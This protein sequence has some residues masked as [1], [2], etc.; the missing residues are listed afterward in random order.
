[1]KTETINAGNSLIADF[2]LGS[3]LLDED[4]DKYWLPEEE[5]IVVW[6]LTYH[7]SWNS[8]MP[9]VEKIESLRNSDGYHYNVE[10]T[11]TFVRIEIDGNTIVEVSNSSKIV[12]VWTAVVHYLTIEKPDRKLV[13]L[14]NHNENTC[15]L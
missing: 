14:R 10:I 12:A 7:E 5:P 6:D 3:H 13:K 15:S 1:M 2:M 11:N 8:L 4:N 9:V